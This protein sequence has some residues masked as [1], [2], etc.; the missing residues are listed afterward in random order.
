MTETDFQT[1]LASAIQDADT[2]VSAT[3]S[4]RQRNT[5]PE[6]EKISLRP[7]ELKGQRHLQVLFWDGRQTFTRNFNQHDAPDILHELL[8]APHNNFFVRTTSEDIQ[9]RIS[10]KGKVRVHRAANVVLQPDLSHNRI[11]SLLLPED[12]PDAFLQ[13]SGIMSA[14]GTVK[15]SKRAKFVQINRFLDLVTETVNFDAFDHT[16]LQLLDCGC[17]SA[18]LTFAVHHYINDVLN[19]PAETVGV[20]VNVALLQRHAE[21]SDA[22]GWENI[23]FESS[24]I[25]DYQPGVQPDIVLALHACDTATDEALA[26]GIMAESPYIFSVPC[27]HHHLQ[28]Q[29]QQDTPSVLDPV[30]RHNILRERMG[31]ILTDTF[32]ALILRIMGYNAQVVEF[33]SP[34]HT[35]KNLMIR[36]QK[37]T[38]PGDPRYVAE[39]LRLCELWQVEPYL[40]TLLGERFAV[41]LEQSPAQ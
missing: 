6:W 2:F 41:L 35:A 17:G 24:S 39:Y 13:A 21:I 32:R 26:V 5:R 7:V 12:R 30:M 27:C 22:M 16:P 9:V 18:Y 1:M 4:G 36:A 10:K 28:V 33:V 29:L 11:K 20:D 31:D 23:N 38:S 37:T 19:I 14:D 25:I 40:A 8:A 3:F 34:E 15:A